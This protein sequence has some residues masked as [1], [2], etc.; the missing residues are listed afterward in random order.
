M[1]LL[2]VESINYD[3]NEVEVLFDG[4]FQNGFIVK[5][6]FDYDKEQ[7]EFEDSRTGE[8]DYFE[9]TNI[10]LWYLTLMDVEGKEFTINNREL[11]TIK[12]MIENELT[13]L[14][15]DYINDN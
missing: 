3:T 14:L 2:E 7:T 8:R 13:N 6:D 4:V 11:N 12:Q 5:T 1:E 10:S 15:T 9:A